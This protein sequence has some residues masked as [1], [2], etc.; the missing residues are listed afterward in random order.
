MSKI[1]FTVG[2]TPETPDAGQVVA[3]PKSDGKLYSKDENGN[4]LMLSNNVQSVNGQDGNVVLDTDDVTEGAAN[5]YFTDQ[6]ADDRADARIA[7][8]KGQA[9]GLAT[10]DGSSKLTASQLCDIPA[11]DGIQYLNGAVRAVFGSAVNTIAE[12]NDNRLSA[13]YE[14]RVKKNPGAGEY[15]SVAAAASAAAAL[16]TSTTPVVI[17]IFPGVY[18]ES[19]T[20]VLVPY[21][22]LMGVSTLAVTIKNS[23]ATATVVQGSDAASVSQVQITSAS[24]AGARAVTYAGMNMFQ[25]FTLNSVQ[26]DN[27]TTSLYVNG[28][29]SHT[30]CFLLGCHFGETSPFGS[31]A[32]VFDGASSIFVNQL[33]LGNT[34]ANDTFPP[35]PA[36]FCKLSGSM[37]QLL[38]SNIS[39]VGQ[40][41][42][43]ALKA[44][45]GAQIRGNGV[46]LRGYSTGL[47]I[48]NTG[49][50][51]K[52]NVTGGTFECLT[53]DVKID[54]PGATGYFQGSATTSKILIDSGV[55]GVTMSYNDISV[56]GFASTGALYLGETQAALVNVYPMINNSAT[57]GTYDGGVLSAGSG[58]TLNVSTGGYGYVMTGTDPHVLK[59]IEFTTPTLTLT[60]NSDVYVYYTSGGVLTSGA[61]LPGVTGNII[62]GRVITD[63]TSIVFIDKI[64]VDAHHYPNKLDRFIREG[65]GSLHVS[66]WAAT[67]NSTTARAINLTAGVYYYSQN[68]ITPSGGT[69]ITFT[70]VHRDGSGGWTLTTGQTVV[71][72][73]VYDDNSSTPAPVT[74]GGFV[75]HLLV[76]GGAGSAEKYF[77]ILGQEVHGSLAAA[78][79][80]SLPLVPSWVRDALV[81]VYSF[82]TQQGAANFAGMIKELPA[83]SGGSGS[84][85]GSTSDHGGL[86]GLSD[87]D[88][89]QYLP[90]SGGRAMAGDLPMGGNNITGVNQVDGVQIS[91][92]ASRHSF[93]GSDALTPALAADL[94]E[95]S[96]SA[97]T[98]GTNNTKVP[99]ADHQHAHGNRGGGSLHAAATGS[100]AGFM[101]AADKTKLDTVGS[102]A[103]VSSVNG[104]TGA[105]TFGTD[106]VAEGSSNLYWTQS[107]F[108]TSFSAKSTSNLSEGSNLY[109]TSSRARA[110]FSVSGALGYDASTGVISLG[111]ATTVVAGAMSASD[112]SKIDTIDQNTSLLLAS[113]VFS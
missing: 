87:D 108:D 75:K 83:L 71:P 58:L 5:K 53:Y 90:V 8:A 109:F 13:Q 95:L 43:T 73:D 59:R 39:F 105:V 46:S 31:E 96:D 100:T 102:G 38:L 9:N 97:A 91:A 86:T 33:G 11:A 112:K 78:Q 24:G 32:V 77:L 111:N 4:E 40:N 63:A 88:H 10:L 79:A 15:S 1:T 61:S 12:G 60:A 44:S 51:S 48:E 20:I 42:A 3:Y 101:S 16:A 19:S 54:H 110:S 72:N 94:A 99:R 2:G 57:M 76:G 84:S 70:R 25:P 52:I 56:G 104:L 66:G 29:G 21:V 45:N 98:A 106:Q 35:A 36:T 18:T 41:G 28:T 14:L 67:E 80:G 62:L 47:L 49:S 113:Q 50:A 55:S 74:A 85:S 93:S 81:K 107:R 6:R 92:H 37:A 34:T 68:R 65:L 23:T 103:N 22:H 69:G 82:I 27:N 30:L 7:A 89:P 17:R 26:F 64:P